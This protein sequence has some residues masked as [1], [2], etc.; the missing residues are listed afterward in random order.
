VLSD[1]G[2][3]V[4]MSVGRRSKQKQKTNKTTLGLTSYT[5]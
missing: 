3:L 1:D 5:D 4:D 2:I